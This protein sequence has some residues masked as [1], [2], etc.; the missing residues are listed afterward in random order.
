MHNI[1]EKQAQKFLQQLTCTGFES[2]V[3]RANSDENHSD[4]EDNSEISLKTPQNHGEKPKQLTF[5]LGLT[6]W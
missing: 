1:N 4:N 5:P 3:L 2:G 6:K